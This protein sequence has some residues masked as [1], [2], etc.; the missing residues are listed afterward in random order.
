MTRKALILFLCAALLGGAACRRIEQPSGTVTLSFDVGTPATRASEPGDGNAADGGGIF[1]LK[2]GGVVKPDLIVFIA[3]ENG[4]IIKSYD[5]LSDANDAPTWRLTESVGSL[6]SN[7]YDEV[8]TGASKRINVA[9]SFNQAGVYS[10]Y[11][12]ANVRGED[13]NFEI[14]DLSA[15]TNVAELENKILSLTSAAISAG[16]T[17][18]VGD[19]MPL[20]ARGTLNVYEN[21]SN[22]NGQASLSMLRCFAKVQF[23]FKNLTGAAEPLELR[24]IQVIIYHMNVKQGYLFQSDPDFVVPG[25]GSNYQH[26]TWRSWTTSPASDPAF[27]IARDGTLSLFQTPFFPS[28]APLQ[29]QPSSGNRYLCDISFRVPKSG[30]T[31]NSSQSGTFTAYSFTNLPIHDALSQDIQ[32]LGRN[33]SLQIETTI[34]AAQVSFNFIVQEW[35]VREEEVFFH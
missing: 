4:A 17:P 5:G 14:P 18:A 35:T 15:V 1:C 32:A 12:I 11:A 10:V 24:H 9:F 13:A 23:T 30:Q 34:S 16:Q 3:D 25:S 28:T 27:S 31:Y 8:N 29:S 20:T 22:Y 21:N 6:D 19:R 2:E 7:D 26:F 33:Q